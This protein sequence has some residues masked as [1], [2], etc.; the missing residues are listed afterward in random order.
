MRLTGKT[1]SQIAAGAGIIAGLTLQAAPAFA[2]DTVT[3]AVTAG[4]R[5]ASVGDASMSSVASSHA[6]QTSSGSMTL[7]ADDS[8]GSGAGWN[9]T[10]LSSA[11]AYSGSA[12]GSAM[13]A[14][15]FALTSAALPAMTAGQAV[16]VTAAMGPEASATTGTLNVARKVIL[17]GP[18][19][20][21]GTYT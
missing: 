12:G 21:V 20:G 10:I 8:S 15:G 3:Q 17:A 1:L 6:V 16:N 11:F 19:F 9:V 7:T 4:A 14:N 2:L 13:P 18:G 5:T